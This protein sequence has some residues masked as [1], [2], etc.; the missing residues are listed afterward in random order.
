MKVSY[1]WLKEYIDFDYTPEELAEKLTLAGLEVDGVEYKGRDIQDIVIGKITEK[2]EHENADKLSVCKVDVGKSEDLQIVCGAKN[3][4]VGDKVPVALVGTTMPN[5]M[6]IKKAK[7]RG[8]TSYGMMCSTNELN[9]PDDGVDGLFILEGDIKVGNKLVDELEID[10]IVIELD[11]TP[12]FAHCLSMIGVAREISAIIDKDIKYPE[13]KVEEIEESIEDWIDVK[14]EA[15]DLCPRYTGRVI[16]G[17]EVSDSPLWLKKK[18]EAVGIRPINNIVDITNFILMELGQPL[19][20]FDYDKLADN[21]VIV[22]RAK[23]DER[24]VTLDEEERD[25]NEE[26]L[27]IADG[28]KAICVAGVMG[29][30][31]SEVD[32]GTKRIFLESANFNPGS[33]R[34][35][36]RKLSIHSDASHRFERG[37]DINIVEYAL[38]RAAQL[39]AELSGGKIVKGIKDIYPNKVEDKI[40]ELRPKRVSNLLGEEFAKIKIK[41]LLERLHFSVEDKGDKLAVTIPAYRVDVEEEIDLVEEVARLYGYDKLPAVEP[42]GDIIQGKKSWKQQVKDQTRIL[43][44]KLGLF[45]VQNYSFIN[46]DFFDKINLPKDSFIRDRIE[47]SNPLGKEYSILR[48]TLIPGLL[49][50]VL[51]NDNRKIENIELFELGKVFIPSEGKE[52]PIEELKLAAAIMK[53]DLEDIWN[54]NASGFFYLKG[55]L[56]NYFDSLGIRGVEFEIG[57]HP[58]MHPG[59]TTKIKVNGDVLGYLG[60]VHPD[61]QENYK[62]ENRVTIFEL[63][64]NLIVD[65]ATAQRNYNPLPKYPA[66]TRDIA[67]VVSED[68]N[69]KQIEDIILSIGS[70]ILESVELFDLYQGEQ[71]EDG[72]KSLAYSLIYRVSDRTLTDDEVNSVQEKIEKELDNKLGAKIRE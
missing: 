65:N 54:V 68:I 8:V 42:S 57:K 53:D 21:K 41:K 64:F 19:H 28:E 11:L 48:T 24:V 10:D 52:L 56:E 71:V 63:D 45:E 1:K 17:V 22:R 4:S 13:V 7:L 14:V 33:V 39:I 49:N 18:L 51:L 55:I 72:Y 29:G 3:M 50:N 58:T 26:M 46:P 38:D 23:A 43:L 16:T 60:E 59:R 40:I 9:L 35:T 27:V 31:N 66:S 47:L 32:S 15:L 62:F 37:V 25:L 20:A 34:K 70:K 5:G 61:V 44:S 69:T 2:K 67:L 36:S 6:E 12:N 30:T